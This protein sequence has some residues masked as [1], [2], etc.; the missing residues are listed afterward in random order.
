MCLTLRPSL[1]KD[2]WDNKRIRWKMVYCLRGKFYP[3][4]IRC[5]KPYNS[6]SWNRA[7]VVGLEVERAGFHVFLTKK[8]ALDIAKRYTPGSVCKVEVRGFLRSGFF[9]DAY[10]ETWREMRFVK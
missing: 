8:A 1:S 9:R 2:P 3:P 10:S 7:R 4:F 5:Q 6:K